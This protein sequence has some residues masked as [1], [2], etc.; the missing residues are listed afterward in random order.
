MGQ[1]VGMKAHPAPRAPSHPAAA[2]APAKPTTPAGG[3][4]YDVRPDQSVEL[5]K[6][7]HIL[8]RDGKLN[9][10]SR[11]K[12]KQVYHLFN[13]IEPLLVKTQAQHADVTLVDHGAGKSY[14]GFILYDLFFKQHAP[15]G[16]IVGVE[17]R[18]DLVLKSAQLAQRLGF[19][20][21]DFLNLSVAAS[22][23]SKQLPARIDIVTALHACDTAT[24]DAIKFGIDHQAQHMVLVPCCQAEVAAT[25]RASKSKTI[26]DNPLAE[27]WRRPIH[28]R[29]FGS[30]LT[31]V[32][33]CLQLEAHGY[34]VTVTELVGWEHSMKNEL[35]IATRGA[36]T[37]RKSAQRL[38][39]MLSQLGLD[40]MRPRFFTSLVA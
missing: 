33:R 19:K 6:E 9:Q 22:S 38:D 26:H 28:T 23:H 2:S 18:D 40:D 34:Q 17:T 7:L 20:G 30:Q 24:D 3:D 25:L 15:Q 29:E 14:L 35:I 4:K 36:T 12:L 10:D 13:F 5:L 11:R 16:K 1:N 39:T 21:M 27:L 31:N 8:T 32:L 37:Q